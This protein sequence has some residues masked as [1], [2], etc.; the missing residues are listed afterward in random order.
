MPRPSSERIAISCE[1]MLGDELVT[2]GSLLKIKDLYEPVLFQCL[3]HDLESDTTWALCQYQ[4]KW[5]RFHVGRVKRLIIPKRS[6]R[7]NNCRN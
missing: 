7:K 1:F 3:I 2:P 6:W 4:G 5:R